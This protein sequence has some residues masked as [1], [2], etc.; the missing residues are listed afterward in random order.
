M[1]I[2]LSNEMKEV[3]A[4]QTA[5]IKP[6]D[7]S[8]MLRS[9]SETAL[10]M[11]RNMQEGIRGGFQ[12]ADK[13]RLQND[14]FKRNEAEREY[15]ERTTQLNTELAQKQGEERIKYQPKYE[16]E[17]KLASD[18]YEAAINKVGNFEI[19]E[20][21]KRS[22]NAW[23]NRNASNYQYE[24]Y[25]NDT[26]LQEK[27]MAQALITD[28][29]KRIKAVSAA[30]NASS[31]TAYAKDPNLGFAHGEQLIR[32]FYKNRMG[33][34]DEVVDQYVKDYKSKGYI[35]MAARLA[36]VTDEVNKNSAYN[37]SIKFINDGIENGFIDAADGIEAKRLLED[38]KLDMIAETAP[39]L[40][41]NDDG[42]FNFTAA[43]RYAPDLT[44]KEL[45]KKL[46]GTK[47]AN[48]GAKGGQEQI[49]NMAIDEFYRNA[50]QLGRSGL[51]KAM[52]AA[53]I[54]SAKDFVERNK[55]GIDSADDKGRAGVKSILA[56][57]QL[58]DFLKTVENGQMVI[59]A[60]G[61]M[62]PMTKGETLESIQ[63]QGASLV[64]AATRSKLLEMQKNVIAD[65]N[66]QLQNTP[67]E[68]LYDQT[69][70]SASGFLSSK[71][72]ALMETLTS[73]SGRHA[74]THNK[75]VTLG[76][77]ALNR[78][79][80]MEFDI[81]TMPISTDV[82]LGY[83]LQGY[84]RGWTNAARLYNITPKM[85]EEKLNDTDLITQKE[86]FYNDD[87]QQL[88]I[89]ERPDLPKVTLA[90]AVSRELG[91]GML[92]EMDDG[93]FHS[94]YGQNKTKGQVAEEIRHNGGYQQSFGDQLS[95]GLANATGKLLDSIAEFPLFMAF[96][97][98][99]KYIRELGESQAR[100]NNWNRSGYMI[101]DQEIAGA[102]MAAAKGIKQSIKG[103]SEMPKNA[104]DIAFS[105]DTTKNEAITRQMQFLDNIV[106]PKPDMA[107]WTF[108]EYAVRK[109]YADK[110][111]YNSYLGTRNA[112]MN[113]S[114]LIQQAGKDAKFFRVDSVDAQ[115]LLGDRMLSDMGMVPS[116]DSN[117]GREITIDEVLKAGVTPFSAPKKAFD[118]AS[119]QDKFDAA[120]V[121][122]KTPMFFL[123]NSMGFLWQ[124]GFV[125]QFDTN[126][127]E[128]V[129]LLGILN[130]Y[131]SD[132]AKAG[133]KRT[134]MPTYRG[135]ITNP[136]FK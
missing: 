78:A 90:E 133:I 129:Y 26:N 69:L 23:N 94:I 38:Q 20:G 19:R 99:L 124:D 56:N 95:F 68:Q 1:A 55:E 22:I 57:K 10:Q 79:F 48:A 65:M 18:K 37:E 89:R 49:Q 115:Q 70:W 59:T 32:D 43:H 50:M 121:D 51:I 102:F 64:N 101:A 36:Q 62:R 82:D 119:F 122:S 85:S 25:K 107:P 15:N 116:N 4:P 75:Y 28:N 111:T 11:N 88:E 83:A 31:L 131:G 17:M 127:T 63:A 21:S 39:G 71:D 97:P 67:L 24:N 110:D 91:I 84:D 33:L 81:H 12:L 2:P 96:K 106:T 125:E 40:I 76:M 27:S 29:E 98:Q 58:L 109:G 100:S 61:K 134:P 128:F 117:V 54:E 3:R 9:M 87:K 126:M 80:G 53:G 108:Q 44:R 42:T 46:S 60:E 73:W 92:E 35:A 103:V 74:R 7:E 52:A 130:Q 77:K 5:N 132:D 34:P 41:F 45:Y 136:D 113:T 30:D 105:D 66:R 16:A 14:A 123:N 114:R 6:I 120:K 104:L 135:P 118:K 47:G 13:V 112:Y 86:F 72:K 8:Q 93:M